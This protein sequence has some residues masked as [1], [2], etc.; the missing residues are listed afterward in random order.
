[1][2]KIIIYVKKNNYLL[3]YSFPA[4]FLRWTKMAIV[5]YLVYFNQPIQ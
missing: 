2:A 4:L 1:M 5:Q 3:N